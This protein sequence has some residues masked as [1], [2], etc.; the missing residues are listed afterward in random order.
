MQTAAGHRLAD[1]SGQRNITRSMAPKLTAPH[2]SR[3]GG[4][5]PVVQSH[6]DDTAE[7]APDG[8]HRGDDAVGPAAAV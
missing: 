1:T 3:C 4:I 8:L 6:C 5:E 7:D 2:P